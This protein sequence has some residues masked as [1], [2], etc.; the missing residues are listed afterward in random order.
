MKAFVESQYE[1]FPPV[2]VFHSRGFNN[3]INGIHGRSLRITHKD[4]FDQC[5]NKCV[6]IC[7]SVCVD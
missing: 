5:V 4:K 6:C 3:K 2:W 7:K 1:Y